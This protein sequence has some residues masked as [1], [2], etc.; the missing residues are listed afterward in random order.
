MAVTNAGFKKS[1]TTY[2]PS[3]NVDIQIGYGRNYNIVV[4]K[5]YSGKKY[6]TTK[7]DLKKSWKLKYSYLSE[8]DRTILQNLH[9]AADGTFDTFLF[10]EDNDFTGTLG[11]D[12]F[13]V[14]F[15]KDDLTFN[16]I[17]VGAYSVS[18]SIEEEL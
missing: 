3:T 16:Q 14:R 5:S 13:T 10:S 15:I 11:T 18:L 17:A 7:H 1:S 6:T 2:K 9:D 12:H 4:N 8:A